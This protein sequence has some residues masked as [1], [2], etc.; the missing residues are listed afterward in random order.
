MTRSDIESTFRSE[1]PSITTRALGT[2]LLHNWCLVGDKQVCAMA[3]CIV[4]QDGTVIETAEDEKSYDLTEEIPNFYDI[5]EYPGG[6]VTY[7]D[8]K[9][10]ETT[11]AKLYRDHPSWRGRA[12]GTPQ[13][14]YRR[15][16]WL[17]MDRAIDS[18]EEDLKVYAVLVSDDFDDDEKTP[19]NELSYLEPFHEAVVKY[20]TWRAKQKVGK[21][22][23]SDKAFAEFTA[24]VKW[25]RSEINKTKYGPIRYEART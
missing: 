15:G 3:R 7:D 4:D 20:L 23:D 18:N 2:A 10:I 24:Y 8:K 5:D 22:P 25:M 1:N 14:Y 17:H 13:E 11:L 12:A 6:G 21:R 9:I 19:F 16:P